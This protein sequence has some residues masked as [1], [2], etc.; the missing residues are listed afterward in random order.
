MRTTG[1]Y[2]TFHMGLFDLSAAFDL[3]SLGCKKNFSPPY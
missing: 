2:R 1:T 3:S